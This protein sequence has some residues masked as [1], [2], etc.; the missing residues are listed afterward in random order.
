[1]KSFTVVLL[2]F[3]LLLSCSNFGQLTYV[4]ELPKKLDENS[5]IIHYSDSTVW[6]IEDNGNQDEIYQVDFLGNLLKEIEV[7]NAK[8]GDWE[9]LTKDENGNL[10]IG[11][12]GNN[13]NKR[14][15]L[16]IYKLPNPQNES[17][18]KI[19]AE[20]IRFNYPEQTEFPPER[21][22]LFYDAEAFFYHSEFLYIITKNRAN[23]FPGHALLYK[24]PAQEGEFNA[25][26]IGNFK[27]CEDWETCQITA[28]DISPD[29]KTIVL[30]SYGKLWIIENFTFDDFSKGK[31]KEIDLGVRTQ[32]ESVCFLDKNTLLLSD[33]KR[34]NT[35]GNLY[36]FKMPK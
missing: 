11:D 1:M 20:Q 24:I 21:E 2:T 8:N 5:G 19:E 7:K 4:T 17:G 22:K 10:Y 29:G 15:D 14:K 18:D 31:I 25:E 28:A 9:D 23:P 35:G 36:S 12:F 26:Y 3:F 34:R 32:L 13:V 33:E 27:T 30:L 16:V 6:F